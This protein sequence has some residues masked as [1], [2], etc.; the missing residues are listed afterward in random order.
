MPNPWTTLPVSVAA[1]CLAAL[2]LPSSVPAAA[3]PQA[4]TPA[5]AVTRSPAELE[6]L[7]AQY[8]RTKPGPA[9]DALA[10]QIDH[11]AGQR[12]ATV[13][14]LYWHTDL[15]AA[16]AAAKASG[17]PILALRMLGRLD[18]DLSCANSRLFR[19]T[20]YANAEI[21]KLLRDKFIL[22]WSSERPVPRV[23]IDFGDGRKLEGTTTGNSAHYLLDET[24]EVVDVL[25]GMYAPVAF[26]AELEKSLA[27]AN[28]VGK[29]ALPNRR[30]AIVK[31]HADALDTLDRAW[32]AAVGT[33]YLPD[34][35]FLL[36]QHDIDSSLALAQ[37]ATMAKA[38]IEVPQLAYIASGA[39]PGSV[40]DDQV[41]LWAAIGQKT[42]NIGGAIGAPTKGGI[43]IGGEVGAARPG[44]RGL[45]P[46][47]TGTTPR[48]LDDQSRALV[49]RLHDAG[50]LRAPADELARVIA[51]LEQHLVADSAL[52]Q[53][54][55]RRQI[56]GYLAG[57]ERDFAATN[58][59]IYEHVF[60]TPRTD[61]WLGLL[62]RTDFTG[63]PGDG[64]V[65]PGATTAGLY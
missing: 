19:A 41:A 47:P 35:R 34:A 16:R 3:P 32:T 24:G 57:G 64:V 15:D 29:L 63:L 4:A 25:P 27:L 2:A 44:R 50:P 38:Y 6:R 65:L 36:T 26:K 17:K 48:V 51:R 8:D 49:A 20:L 31:Y 56:H 33:P 28:A 55:L 42:W 60:H 10:A 39:D 30:A 46:A 7:L 1:G 18:E 22:Y 12:Y 59:W 40:P 52:N 58:A 5:P 13:S 53:F 14:R 9:R 54:R 37:R 61:A 11:V 23:T 62:P 43:T 21:A 45:P